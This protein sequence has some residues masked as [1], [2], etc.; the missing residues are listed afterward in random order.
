MREERMN[1]TTV[2][3]AMLKRNIQLHSGDICSLNNEVSMLVNKNDEL[4][5]DLQDL[6]T[7]VLL[8]CNPPDDCNDIGVLKKYMKNCYDKA[9]TRKE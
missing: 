4:E 8:C 1:T 6:R 3:N 5:A 2:D 9:D 7:T